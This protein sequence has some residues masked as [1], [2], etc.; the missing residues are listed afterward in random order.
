[1][2]G[3]P[4]KWELQ[5]QVG[6]DVVGYH[7]MGGEKCWEWMGMFA[8]IARHV[9]LTILERKDMRILKQLDDGGG[10]FACNGN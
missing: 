9:C 4:P 1:M 8:E 6:D 5:P 7:E 2:G 10:T 3:N